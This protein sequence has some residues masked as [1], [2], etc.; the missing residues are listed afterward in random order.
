MYT[1]GHTHSHDHA[2]HTSITVTIAEISVN[3]ILKAR[4]TRKG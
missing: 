2:Y 4:R 1:H 3:K